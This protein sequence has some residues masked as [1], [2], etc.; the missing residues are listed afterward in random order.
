M[1]ITLVQGGKEHIE[2]CI[3]AL[4][5]S[6]LGEKYFPSREKAY[7]GIIEF[8]EHGTLLIARDDRKRFIGFLCYLENGA[9]HAFPYLHILAISAT[10]RGKGYGNATMDVFEK[11]MFRAKDKIFLVVA[12]FNPRAQH[13]YLQ[14]G[15]QAVGTIPD[16]YR[17]GIAE[18]LMMK[19]KPDENNGKE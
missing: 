3:T 16:L 5:T 11:M 9:F 2:D 15:Y 7:N 4:T 6:A 19:I 18:H 8:V 1:N 14:R 12:D 10:K 17:A 13:F